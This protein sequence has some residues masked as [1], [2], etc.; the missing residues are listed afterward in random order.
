MQL[1]V[2]S[3]TGTG[4]ISKL[5]PQARAKMLIPEDDF[6]LV[7]FNQIES[8]L[9]RVRKDLGDA[10]PKKSYATEKN[11]RLVLNLLMVFFEHSL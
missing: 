8:Y 9:A 1:L 6:S 5:I 4:D 7:F 3:K 10:H 11:A 2:F